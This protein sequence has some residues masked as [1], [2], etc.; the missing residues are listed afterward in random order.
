MSPLD[1][2]GG[3][4]DLYYS[5]KQLVEKYNKVKTKTPDLPQSPQIIQYSSVNIEKQ[6]IFE[7]LLK[8]VTPQQSNQ[9]IPMEKLDINNNNGQSFGYIVY[10]KTNIDLT[11]GAVLQIDGRVCDTVMVLVNGV[12][13]SPYLE[14]A[15]DLSKF[16]TSTIENST[17]VLT[18]TTLSGATLDLVVENWGRIN[19]AVYVAFKGLWHGGVSINGNY[20]RDWTIY[21]LEFKKSWTNSLQNWQ[22]VQLGT[23][24][25]SLYKG[26]LQ[27][28]EDPKDTFIYMENW[29]KGIVIVNG[30]VL[31]RYAHMGPVQTIYLPAPFLKKGEND[32]VIFEHFQ[33]YVS[34]D[35]ANTNIYVN[36]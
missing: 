8:T 28:T 25:P 10:R 1:E 19:V 18:N 31:G 23:Q 17:L 26:S 27:I 13:V 9:L 29:K 7:N 3:Y 6:I 2:S 12:I 21:P 35:F 34:V 16:G 24:G 30:F 15:A 36:H 14:R 20:L 4:T 32:I 33:G 11:A 22:D 5:V